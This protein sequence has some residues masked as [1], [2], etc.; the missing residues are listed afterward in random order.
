MTETITLETKFIVPDDMDEDNVRHILGEFFGDLIRT[1]RFID[2]RIVDDSIDEGEKE[3]MLEMLS[4]VD[5]G[6]LEQL[7]A[8]IEEQ[9]EE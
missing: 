9:K 3:Q 2:A 8:F 4:F 7:E 5:D 6:N 1:D